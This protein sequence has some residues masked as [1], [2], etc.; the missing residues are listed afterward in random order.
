MKLRNKKTG[1][2]VDLSV[3]YIRDAHNGEFIQIKPVACL[4]DK[5]SYLYDTFAK[6]SEDWEDYKP[7]EPYIKDK[8]VRKFVR[9]W[10]EHWKI[11]EV[12]IRFIDSNR[13]DL[14]GFPSSSSTKTGREIDIQRTVVRNEIIYGN[15]YTIDELCGEEEECER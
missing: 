12:I 14:I 6:F 13:I 9:D 3:G 10:A 5:G 11:D 8:K 1:E 7:A 15:R 2:I 4:E